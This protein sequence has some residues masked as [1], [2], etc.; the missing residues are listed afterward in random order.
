M[1]K[2]FKNGKPMQ[3]LAVMLA[4]IFACTAGFAYANT[5]AEVPSTPTHTLTSFKAEALVGCETSAR[6]IGFTDIATGR[7]NSIS[8]DE[9]TFVVESLNPEILSAHVGDNAYGSSNYLVMNGVSP[10]VATLRISVPTKNIMAETQV[11]VLGPEDLILENFNTGTREVK[12]GSEIYVSGTYDA[13]W[14]QYFTARIDRE[15][16][17]TFTSSNPD[18]VAVKVTGTGMYEQQNTKLMAVGKGTATITVTINGVGGLNNVVKTFDV[19]VT[20]NPKATAPKILDQIATGDTISYG[21]CGV[22][23]R[24]KGQPAVYEFW[25][26]TSP[27]KNFKKVGQITIVEDSITKGVLRKKGDNLMSYEAGEKL[28]F[29]DG[30][31]MKQN[32]KYYYKMRVKYTGVEYDNSWS[33]WSRVTGAYWTGVKPFKFDDSR[34]KLNK[35]T[36]KVTIPKPAT[37]VQ[38]YI[39]S[40]GASKHL[41]YNIFGQEV[42]YRSG[43]RRITTKRIFTVKNIDGMRVSVVY[44][45]VPYTKHGKYYY[46]D[47]YKPMKSVNRFKEY[48]GAEKYVNY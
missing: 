6:Y 48:F 44:D 27:K 16:H 17:M 35:K 39:Y 30:K 3:I 7:L 4:L 18:V 33:R 8:V 2:Y 32:T 21:G 42:R 11:T 40:V 5:E 47:G 15:K 36:R 28:I 29:E 46:V 13:T 12:K 9:K 31:K 24:I 25:R 20:V 19:N 26:S 23:F 41:G 37:K 10:G 38:G 22:G 43:A 34:I 14:G 1:R 45:V